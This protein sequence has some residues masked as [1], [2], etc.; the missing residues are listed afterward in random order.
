[1][2][3]TKTKGDLAELMVAADLVDKGY[4]IAI[5]YGEDWD[6]DL[7]FARPGSDRLE[8]VQVKHTTPRGEVIP[9]RCRSSSLTK[10]KV[11]RIKRYTARTID[12]IAAYCPETGQCY[13]ISAVELGEG[14]DEISLRLGP[15]KNCQR[16][17]VRYAA[18]YT[19]PEP[20][21]QCPL[22]MMEP[23]GLEPATSALQTPRSP[24]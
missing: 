9:V 17:G 2:A 15:T 8:R 4:K 10:G 13:Y 6:F 12:W 20:Q 22:A 3:T 24:S 19:E 7:I 21:R 18:D 11:K 23:A 5:P 14:R 16:T 1:M